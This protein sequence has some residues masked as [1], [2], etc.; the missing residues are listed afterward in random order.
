MIITSILLIILS[1][2]LSYYYID[3]IVDWIFYLFKLLK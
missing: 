1:L 3:N 2:S